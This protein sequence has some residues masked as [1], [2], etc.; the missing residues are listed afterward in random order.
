MINRFNKQNLVTSI[1]IVILLSPFASN[2]LTFYPVERECPLGGERFSFT[3]VSS[4]TQFGKRLDLKPIGAMMAPMPLAICPNNGFI[5]YKSD[6]SEVELNNL[7]KFVLSAE[8]QS[9]R[10][11]NTDYYLLAKIYEY[12][13]K[14]FSEIAYTYLKAS[15]EAEGTNNYPIYMKLSASYYQKSVEQE[16]L[17]KNLEFSVRFLLVEIN[18][19][20]GNF[21]LAESNLELLSQAFENED[22]ATKWIDIE[23]DL[24][25][26]K[27]ANPKNI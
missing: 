14:P 23:R 4:Y 13:N 24:I 5:M 16:H 26:N 27:D 15:W 17:F 22:F 8:Y 12:L 2:A 7:E 11:T 21:K 3:S 10:D 6:F 25:N 20:L 9:L 1:A 18:R 19:L